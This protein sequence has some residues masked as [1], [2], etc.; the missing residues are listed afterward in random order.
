MKYKA[1]RITTM[2]S[3]A[4]FFTTLHVRAQNVTDYNL[5]PGPEL[6]LPIG[7]STYFS[8]YFSD[9]TGIPKFGTATQFSNVN[10]P[11]W[12]LNGKPSG[13]VANPEGRLVR[14]LTFTKAAYFAPDKVPKINPVTIAVKFKANDTT[15]EE[16]TLVCNV[17]IVDPGQNWY[18]AYICTKSSK[19]TIISKFR[20]FTKTTKA[21]GSASM[22][23]D[24][25]APQ[26]GYVIIN[27]EQDDKIM[28]PK[29]NG[30]YNFAQTDVEKAPN[31]NLQEKTS[32]NYAGT[33]AHEQGLLFEYDPSLKGFKGGLQGAGISFDVTGTDEFW[34][35]DTY[36]NK[37]K[38]TLNKVSENAFD[39]MTLGSNDDN[40]K[41][42]KHGFSIEFSKSKDTSYT[43]IGKAEHTIITKEQYHA[44]L[45]WVNK[46]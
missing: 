37:L 11:T 24:A 40:L 3:A 34:R 43:D 19:E 4:L 20:D 44:V 28:N 38:K 45:L 42:I 22:L 30:Y 29:V 13:T 39:G 9:T 21:V 14:D 26:N 36:T 46:E 31:G 5:L 12:T 1:I 2:M 27:T 41:K 18:F 7:E 10:P 25:P 35:P 33:P 16:T 6:I 17:K 32:R 8:I 23:V 15:K